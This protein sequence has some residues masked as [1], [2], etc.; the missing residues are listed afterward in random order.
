MVNN[1]YKQTGKKLYNVS[2]LVSIIVLVALA[3]SLYLL[4]SAYQ[5][6]TNLINQI[7]FDNTNQLAQMN[8]INALNSK[9][10]VLQT[11]L[12][13]SNFNLNQISAN[14]T[15]TNNELLKFKNTTNQ[16]LTGILNEVNSTS[17]WQAYSAVQ[18]NYNQSENY[19]CSYYFGGSF[20]TTI[21]VPLG[22]S[23]TMGNLLDSL[24]T[25]YNMSN[26]TGPQYA[27]GLISSYIAN[28]SN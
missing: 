11:Q 5:T 7:N 18:A 23:L 20:S 27:A 25:L 10:G 13:Q 15:A 3:S 21:Y 12:N 17:Y 24:N 1:N 22:C 16:Q 9:I 28:N 6:Q 19:G 26:S 4:Y 2:F 8:M 14:Y